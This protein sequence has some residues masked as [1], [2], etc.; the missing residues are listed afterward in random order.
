MLKIINSERSLAEVNG[1]LKRE[2]EKR[3]HFTIKLNLGKRSLDANAMQHVWFKELSE[4][5]DDSALY[6]K[7]Y[8][9]YTFGMMILS[10]TEPEYTKIIKKAFRCLDY[11]EKIKAMQFID[12]S[13]K[14]NR[15]Q[16]S[17]YM[18]AIK[19]HFTQEGY[20]LSEP[21]KG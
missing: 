18:D 10:A 12:V 1:L 11:D 4:Q 2:F 6:Y 16:M 20:I 21:K 9:K 8:C 5:G 13:S 17:M 14:F 7:C 3:R 19:H 15:E